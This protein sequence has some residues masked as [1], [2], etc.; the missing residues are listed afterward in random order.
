[1]GWRSEPMITLPSWAPGEGPT[2]LLER[3]PDE[4]RTGPRFEEEEAPCWWVL[5]TLESFEG[6]VA[7][8][9]YYAAI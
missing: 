2:P 9:K 6:K 8:E 5:S 7:R 4:V 3:A 1:V